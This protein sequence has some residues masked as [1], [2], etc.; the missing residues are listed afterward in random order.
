MARTGNQLILPTEMPRQ[1]RTKNPKIPDQFDW[2]PEAEPPQIQSHTDAKLRLL[3]AYIDGYFDAVCAIPHMDVLRIAFVDAFSGGGLFKQ[4]QDWRYGSPLV[5]IDAVNRAR[6][7]INKTRRKEFRIEV[8]YFFVDESEDA[9]E[10][11]RN[12]L[13]ATALAQDPFDTIDIRR[14]IASEALPG[15][16]ENIKDWSSTGRSIFFLD[17]CG[18]TDVSHRDVRLIY[19]SLPKSEIIA[20]YNFGAIYDYMTETPK[21]LS[22]V[23][24]IELT[25]DHLKELLIEKESQ[26][27]RFFASRLLGQFF[28]WQIGA[29]FMSRF[30]LR[31]E[32][33]GRDMWFVHYSKVMR[34]R[35]VMND[36]HWSIGNASVTQGDA[37]L[38]M[39]GFRPDWEGQ[40]EIDFGFSQMDEGQM[41]T[42]LMNDFPQFMQ[43]FDGD[44]PP[45]VGELFSRLADTTAA[46]EDQLRAA[47]GA[48]ET[49]S[50]FDFLT[51]S[52][53]KKRPSALLKPHHRIRLP[54]QRR[55]YF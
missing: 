37:G 26:A 1:R 5:M 51:P 38:D 4:G 2:R 20:T 24:P 10:F 15:I 21:F 41:H 18:Y 34:S 43:Q 33:A 25:A 9:V 47:L 23:A 53:E 30:F 49:N 46:T 17:Q 16:I 29:Q 11:L 27:G 31:S 6:K 52:G 36:S 45:T 32:I 40:I 3:A 7:R 14:E 39:V 42:A 19:R 13:D 54:I 22:S 12:S 8:K 28:K 48:L 50:A 55:F 44:E 35:L